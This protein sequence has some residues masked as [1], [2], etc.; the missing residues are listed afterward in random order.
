MATVIESRKGL[1]IGGPWRW[2]SASW[3]LRHESIEPYMYHNVKTMIT[4]PSEQ[5]TAHT[6]NMKQL[7]QVCAE[8]HEKTPKHETIQPHL[9]HGLSSSVEETSQNNSDLSAKNVHPSTMVSIGR[10]SPDWAGGQGSQGTQVY[11]MF[12][13]KNKWNKEFASTFRSSDLLNW[14]DIDLNWHELTL[15]KYHHFKPKM[16]VFPN[17]MFLKQTRSRQVKVPVSWQR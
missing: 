2:S 15:H 13:R 11:I 16:N 7:E 17:G 10:L 1:M 3:W 8:Q 9:T 5:S 12:L 6:H 4:I 14:H